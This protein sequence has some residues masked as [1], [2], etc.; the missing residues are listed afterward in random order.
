MASLVK[1]YS[2]EKLTGQIF[3]PFFIV[4][5]ILNDVGFNSPKILGK[6]ILDPACGDGKFLIR[7]AEK[8]IQYSSESDLQKNLE[9]IYG[10]DIDEKAINVAIKNLNELVKPY[11]IKVNWNVYV[12]NSLHSGLSHFNLFNNDVNVTEFDFIVGNPPYIRIQHLEKEERSFIQK[13]YSF[14]KS[15][16]TDIYI[17]F[18]ELALNLLKDDGRCGYITPNTFFHTETAKDLRSYFSTRQNLIQITNYGHLQLFDNATTYSAIVIFDKKSREKFKFQYAVGENQFIERFI[19]FAEIKNKKFWQLTTQKIRIGKRGKRLGDIAKIHVGITT[20]ADKIYMMPFI[21]EEK[22]Y[23]FL[24]S[25][26]NGII[27]IEKDILKP[28]VKVST[29]KTADE[30]IKEFVLFPYEKING[31]H[32]IIEESKLVENYPLAYK[33]LLSVKDLLLKRD[34]GNPNPV[35]WYAFG[36]TQGLDT[37]FGEK[38]LFSPMNKKPNFIYHKNK[39]ATFYSGYCIKYDGDYNF[40]LKQLNSDRM[41]EFIKISSR[42]FRGGWKAYNK[43]I[44]QEFII[45]EI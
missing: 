3:T 21:G 5:K 18:Y 36:R 34:N 4:D 23:F 42:D 20:L 8:I 25:K 37:T 12:N 26:Y 11:G 38:I 45:Y 39:E 2:K 27:K 31:K 41:Y 14:C 43:K 15:G 16:S 10:W 35:A 1:E 17:A 7:I 22:N 44:V 24:Q 28:I 40:L 32:K 30:P 9:K 19:N 33:Y 29:L 13:N 6:T